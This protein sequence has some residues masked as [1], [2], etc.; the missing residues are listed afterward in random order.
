MPAI[1]GVNVIRGIMRVFHFLCWKAFWMQ[2]GLKNPHMMKAPSAALDKSNA[3]HISNEYVLNNVDSPSLPSYSIKCFL[4]TF[5]LPLLAKTLFYYL[6]QSWLHSKKVSYSLVS[7]NLNL[8]PIPQ[9]TGW[10]IPLAKLPSCIFSLTYSV[11]SCVIDYLTQLQW[12]TLLPLTN[13]RSWINPTCQY[14]GHV[15]GYTQYLG[16]V[17]LYIGSIACCSLSTQ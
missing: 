13:A 5:N 4:C 16:H 2:C 6:W 9:A 3:F 14:L 17:P 7:T 12:K 8:R 15:L 11:L 10:R 1:G